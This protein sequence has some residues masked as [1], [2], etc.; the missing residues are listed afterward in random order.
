MINLRVTKTCCS[1]YQLNEEY[2]E[3]LKF[4]VREKESVDNG[5]ETYYGLFNM[6]MRFANESSSFLCF[7]SL[8]CLL[9]SNLAYYYY[10][11]NT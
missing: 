2:N 9:H 4:S 7:S 3:K 5:I 8:N 1:E 11:T 10:Y 6:A